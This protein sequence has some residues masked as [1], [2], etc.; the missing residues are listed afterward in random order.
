M[1]TLRQ[2]TD[3][4]FG[5]ARRV[6]QEGLRPYVDAVWGWDQADQDRRFSENW[7]PESLLIIEVGDDP[8]GFLHI[9]EQALETKVIGIYIANSCRGK[10]LGSEVLGDLLIR[11]SAEG[12]K[13]TI[14][15]LKC[16]P[17]SRLY[18][19]LGFKVLSETE[20]HIQLAHVSCAG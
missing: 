5:F 17:A 15:V 12:R 8:V 7:E 1:Y 10:G 2:A 9:D 6:K 18:I 4:D 13:T 20:T 11:V 19:R 16:N 14:Q 3:P